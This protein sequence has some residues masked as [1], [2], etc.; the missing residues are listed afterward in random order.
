MDGGYFD[1]SG[2]TAAHEIVTRIKDRCALPNR[3]IR[4]VDVKVIMISNNPRKPSIAP[5]MPA[6]EPPGPKRT[7]S[8]VVQGQFMSELT[9]PLYTFLNARDA[10]GTYAQKNIALEQRRFKAGMTA[11]APTTKDIIYFR[12]RDT[13]HRCRLAGSFRPEPRKRCGINCSLR[14]MLC[15]T[16][17]P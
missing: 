17:P 9:A 3:E 5:A 2:A 7:S 10:H 1:N 16:T 8:T 6:P 11:P 14:T 4:N 15:K 13:R 12:L